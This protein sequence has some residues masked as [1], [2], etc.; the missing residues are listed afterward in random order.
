MDEAG[1]AGVMI[2]GVKEIPAYF[3]RDASPLN[4]VRLCH[5]GSPFCC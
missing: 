2:A 4:E 3:L 1:T 5:V